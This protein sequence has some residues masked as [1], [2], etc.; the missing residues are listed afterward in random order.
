MVILKVINSQRELL[1]TYNLSPS[2]VSGCKI[3]FISEDYEVKPI[4]ISRGPDYNLIVDK[5]TSSLSGTSAFY[6]DTYELG[7]SGVD[8]GYH[9]G[10]YLDAGGTEFPQNGFQMNPS[11][12]YNLN[13]TFKHVENKLNLVTRTITGRI[14]NEFTIN[15][16]ATE[17]GNWS[18]NYGSQG[19]KLADSS[20]L[21]TLQ[22]LGDGGGCISVN[23]DLLTGKIE[24][25][26]GGKLEQSYFV[27][28]GI[29]PLKNYLNNDFFMGVPN[30]GEAPITDIVK[31]QQLAAKNAD[32][33]NFYVYNKILRSD[34]IQ[35]HCLASQDIDEIVL[36]VACGVRNNIETINRFYSY[37]IP[38]SI[39]NI[40]G[41][42]IS[43][44][45]LNAN[46]ANILAEDL[47]G[48]LVNYLPA[49]VNTVNF[50][51]SVGNQFKGIISKIIK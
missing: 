5:F 50:N 30:L 38:G 13:N 19:A 32:L 36:D 26:T 40:I 6:V 28:T 24:L 7:I 44:G 43:D 2:A 21:T 46:D 3:D 34:L 39:S 29:K 11:S 33:K 10:S 15:W 1:S 9:V 42:S 12:M 45:N 25:Y 22:S 41:I 35:Y 23:A 48:R 14:W 37:K 47:A 8:M 4:A 20:T 16:E 27:D 31:N 18:F 17:A 51:F 49:N